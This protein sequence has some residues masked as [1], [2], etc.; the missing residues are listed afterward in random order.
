M[1]TNVL[2]NPVIESFYVSF[3]LRYSSS[4]AARP[5][6]VKRQMCAYVCIPFPDCP[7]WEVTRKAFRHLAERGV[8]Y[9][10]KKQTW[11][12]SAWAGCNCWSQLP[13]LWGEGPLVIVIPLPSSLPHILFLRHPAEQ[14]NF[15]HGVCSSIKCVWERMN[16]TSPKLSPLPSISSS[17][18]ISYALWCFLGVSPPRL[19]PVAPLF[20]IDS[21]LFFFHPCILCLL[22]PSS[23]FFVSFAHEQSESLKHTVGFY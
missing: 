11:G 2:H 20:L 16:Q 6:L 19:S 8:F 15:P 12:Y 7:R 17:L 14:S 22:F 5:T 13:L 10:R 3:T 4:D 1:V 21:G 23:F 9:W 18:Y